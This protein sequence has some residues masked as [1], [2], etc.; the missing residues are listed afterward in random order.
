M[1]EATKKSIVDTTIIDVS[2]LKVLYIYCPPM[3]P[4]QPFC[5]HDDWRLFFRYV[6]SLGNYF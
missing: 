1:F 3:V 2:Q 6:K 5:Y 4:L